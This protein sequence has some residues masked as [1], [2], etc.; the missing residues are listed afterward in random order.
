MKHSF[1][2][3]GSLVLFVGGIL[4]LLDIASYLF[5]PS[6]WT[7][8]AP[9]YRSHPKKYREYEPGNGYPRYYYRADPFLGFDISPLTREKHETSDGMEYEIFANDLGCFD[10]NFREDFS[11]SQTGYVY[12]AGDSFTWGYA[13]Y[14][15][16]FATVWEKK[17]GILAAKCGVSHTGTRHQFE[18]FKRVTQAIGRLPKLVFV[19]FFPNDIVNDVTFPHSTVIEG[20]LVDMVYSIGK[21]HFIRI[22]YEEL[23]HEIFPSIKAFEEKKFKTH[24]PDPQEQNS[25]WVKS[26]KFLKRYSLLTNALYISWYKIFLQ[27]D[28]PTSKFGQ[29]IYR[30]MDKEQIKTEF[31]F[32]PLAEPTKKA[33]KEWSDNAKAQGYHLIFI[34]IPP[35]SNFNDSDFFVQVKEFLHKQHVD[36]IDLAVLFNKEGWNRDN[37]YWQ[38]DTHL[39]GEGNRR[40]G[41]ELVSRF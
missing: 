33:I 35:R 30:V 40:V 7:E 19:G 1:I 8:F 4:F 18:K 37:L 10:R 9:D 31:A 6:S 20:F 23:A 34:L 32:S 3:W 11:V 28:H 15:D 16:K 2:M 24:P 14:E 38:R 36:F 39:N 26:K 25:M 27:K 21:D 29:N 13:D 5:I 22:P 17:T 41:L 12:F